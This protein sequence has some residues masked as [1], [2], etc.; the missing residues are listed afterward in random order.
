MKHTQK[1]LFAVF[2]REP[3]NKRE[4]QIMSQDLSDSDEKTGIVYE[5]NDAIKVLK[6]RLSRADKQTQYNAIATGIYTFIQNTNTTSFKRKFVKSFFDEGDFCL[7][8]RDKHVKGLID[9]L[10]NTGIIADGKTYATYTRYKVGELGSNDGDGSYMAMMKYNGYTTT[11]YFVFKKDKNN[12][13]RRHKVATSNINGQPKD[14]DGNLY[15]GKIA[16]SVL[17]QTL[18]REKQQVKS[19]GNKSIMRTTTRGHKVNNFVVTA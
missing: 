19:Y 5:I 14:S 16:L 2:R 11:E 7:S 13:P 12:I 9:T 18:P 1:E 6:N 15:E 8:T 10:K 4:A 17:K 3:Q